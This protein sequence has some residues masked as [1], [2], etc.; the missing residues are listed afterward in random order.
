MAGLGALGSHCQLV[1]VSGALTDGRERA[2]GS[3]THGTHGL[4]FSGRAGERGEG[5]TQ[6]ISLARFFFLLIYL[7][8]EP[9]LHWQETSHSF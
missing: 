2:C 8:I 9:K 7:F 6:T 5:E 1:A 4:G 3:L